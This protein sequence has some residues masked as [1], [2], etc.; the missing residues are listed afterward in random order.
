MKIEIEK[1]KKGGKS[2]VRQRV[3]WN[4]YVLCVCIRGWLISILQLQTLNTH[5]FV[6]WGQYATQFYVFHWTNTIS[7]LMDK[8]NFFKKKNLTK[9]IQTWKYQ[10]NS[11][12]FRLFF[13]IDFY[14]RISN[15]SH[16]CYTRFTI[17]KYISEM[18]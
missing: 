17:H 6:V 15:G 11:F 9:C 5:L 3:L 2:V 8:R 12:A 16:S 4:F 14:K 10:F 7:L 13:F 18:T 1:L